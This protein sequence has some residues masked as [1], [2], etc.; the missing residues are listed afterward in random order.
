MRPH[1]EIEAWLA[2]LLN[3][4]GQVRAARISGLSRRTINRWL[5][6]E[7]LRKGS[8]ALLVLARSRHERPVPSGTPEGVA[9]SN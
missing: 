1:P 3:E 5:A 7:D 6:G 4:V 9:A 8:I 2:R